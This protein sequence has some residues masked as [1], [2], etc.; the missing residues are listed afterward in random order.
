MRDDDRFNK[1]LEVRTAVMG[2]ARVRSSL[3]GEDDL[4]YELQQLT[5]KIAWGEIWTREGLDRRSR[6]IMTVAMLIALN[7]SAELKAHMIGA[8]N[9]GLTVAELQEMI[10]HSAIYCGFPAALEAMRMLRLVADDCA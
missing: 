4:A 9:N 10:I 2:E 3:L 1:G 8:I 6:S 7:R 5:T